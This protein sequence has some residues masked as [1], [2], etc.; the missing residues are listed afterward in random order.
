M[1]DDLY[2]DAHIG[3]RA[4]IAELE[5]RIEARE[6]EVTESFWESLAPKLREE[7]G[8]LRN[9]PALGTSPSVEPSLDDLTRTEAMLA[10]YLDELERLIATLPA[11]EAEWAIRPD[12][13]ADPPEPKFPFYNGA[14][15]AEEAAM[16]FRHFGA[17]VRERARDAEILDLSPMY[18]ARFRER[19]C[20]F[21]LRATLY[22]AGN[23]QVAEVGMWLVT[24]IP[25]ALPRLVVRHETLVLSVGKVLGLKHEV[26]V[27][28]TSFDGL[29]LI[30]GTKAASD[31]YLVPAVQAQLLALS[32]FDIPTLDV[33]PTA[34][35][36]SLRWRFEPAA[37][38]LDAAVRI[39]TAVRESRPSVR[40]RN[41]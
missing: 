24:S 20:P 5:A 16:L 31:L 4:R 18:L 6:S 29:F 10:A 13:V 35:T 27:G 7:L 8:A 36:A 33:D 21:A 3:L 26:E 40:F 12:D 28:D 23:G 1:S 2:R 9:E 38:A 22:T 39:L 41:E 25:R 11:T 30:E 34:R 32:R 19:G 14:P 37:K 15:S 17:M